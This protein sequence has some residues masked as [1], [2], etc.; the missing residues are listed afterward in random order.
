VERFRIES[1]AVKSDGVVLSCVLAEL[2]RR[3][4]PA[5]AWAALRSSVQASLESTCL[6]TLAIGSDDSDEVR[7]AQEFLVRVQNPNG[8]WPA[9]FGAI[10]MVTGKL[11]GPDGNNVLID[12]GHPRLDRVS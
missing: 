5:G 7:L 2:S 8:S 3:Q 4:L 11:A 6:T 1:A 9:F 10:G 12:H